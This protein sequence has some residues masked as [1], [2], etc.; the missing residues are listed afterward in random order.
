MDYVFWVFNFHFSKPYFQFNKTL[1]N[2]RHQNFTFKGNP[3]KLR[4]V[5]AQPSGNQSTLHVIS[6]T[7]VTVSGTFQQVPSSSCRNQVDYLQVLGICRIQWLAAAPGGEKQLARM[8]LP[9]VPASSWRFSPSRP[10]ST[11]SA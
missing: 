4:P 9:L 8:R 1:S 7:G 11:P 5:R 10:G 3:T 6:K 2:Y